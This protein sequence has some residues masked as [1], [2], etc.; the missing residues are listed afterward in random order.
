MP[1]GKE[2]DL[3]GVLLHYSQT[4]D[5]ILT[6]TFVI[7]PLTRKIDIQ[8][9]Y[10]YTQSILSNI[11]SIGSIRKKKNHIHIYR[12]IDIQNGYWY[13]QSI[14]LYNNGFVLTSSAK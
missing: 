13:T 12:E 11:K 8:N 1:R 3:F 10:W 14:L 2:F 4:L 9:G 5:Q 6:N 7:L